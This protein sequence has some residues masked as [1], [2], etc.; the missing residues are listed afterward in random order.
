MPRPPQPTSATWI[1][2]SSAAWTCGTAAATT[3]DAAA[4][5]PV[6]SRNSRRVVV[7]FVRFVMAGSSLEWWQDALRTVFG[8]GPTIPNRDRPRQPGAFRGVAAGCPSGYPDGKEGGSGR[9][10]A[11][12]RRVLGPVLDSGGHMPRKPFTGKF[13]LATGG[14]VLATLALGAWY[15]LGQTRSAP[16][17]ANPGAATTVIAAATAPSAGRSDDPADAGRAEA[18]APTVSNGACAHPP[19]PRRR[20]NRPLPA[21]RRTNRCGGRSSALGR[22]TI[23]ERGR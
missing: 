9:A 7:C 15:Q 10:H 6:W 11:G 4:R 20:P 18:P 3:A 16:G 19:S 17:E 14:I 23:R 8:K 21:P 5:R 2:L 13:L 1:V 12:C 22:I